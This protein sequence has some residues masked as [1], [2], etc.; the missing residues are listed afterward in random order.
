MMIQQN[1][2]QHTLRN[3]YG[4]AT[5]GVEMPL[6]SK[7]KAIELTRS[8]NFFKPHGDKAQKDAN[9]QITHEYMKKTAISLKNIQNQF[10][11]NDNKS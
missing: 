6:F 9:A 5:S 2:L 8:T 11:H 10:G 1:K 4:I 7:M 3:K